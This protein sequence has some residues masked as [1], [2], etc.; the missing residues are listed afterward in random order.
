MASDTVLILGVG[1]SGTTA[2]YQ[3]IQDIFLKRFPDSVKSVYEPF[4]WDWPQFDKPL[5]EVQPLFSEMSSISYKGILENK[6]IS[7]LVLPHMAKNFVDR[8]FIDEIV[9]RPPDKL[10]LV[11]KLIRANGRYNVF[12][13]KKPDAKI[14]FILRNPLDVVNSVNDMFSFYGDD[15]HL[16]DYD[17]FV[18]EVSEIY[19]DDTLSF[20]R[21]CHVQKQ[22]FFWYFMNKFFLEQSKND[23][24]VLK[25]LYEEYSEFPALVHEKICGFLSLDSQEHPFLAKYTS[26]AGPSHSNIGLTCQEIDSMAPYLEAYEKLLSDFFPDNPVSIEKIKSKY[27]SGK[28]HLVRDERYVGKTPLFLRAVIARNESRKL[29]H[30]IKRFFGLAENRR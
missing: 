23:S 1:R 10:S 25:I 11:A 19:S 28:K 17:R 21:N 26:K 5:Q 24:N 3:H 16:S 13:L 14:I 4:L 12:R 30:K 20:P 27:Q 15:F 2:I 6:E 9:S 18:K 29:S 8:P 7:L 22:A